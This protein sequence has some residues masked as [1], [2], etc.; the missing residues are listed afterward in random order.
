M[1]R[2]LKQRLLGAVIITALLVILVPEWLDGAGHKSRYPGRIEIPAT[3]AIQPMRELMPAASVIEP[4]VVEPKPQ[5]PAADAPQTAEKPAAP[6]HDSS[7]LQAWALQVGSF[8]EEANARLQ[9]DQMRAKGY[10]AYIDER[11]SGDRV[12]YR[13]RI[14]PELDR[15]RID[16]LKEDIFKK[17][18]IKGMVVNHP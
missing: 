15:A 6:A 13:V 17:E 4:E 8:S 7:S 12:R 2:A 1:D 11:K 9:R 10:A 3:P 5:E 16:R 14:G 18:K